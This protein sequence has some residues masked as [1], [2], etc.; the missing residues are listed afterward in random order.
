MYALCT[1]VTWIVIPSSV[2]LIGHYAF[3]NCTGLTSIALPNELTT[4]GI[5]TTV[6]TVTIIYVIIIMITNPN[7]IIR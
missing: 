1:S 7:P 3:Y 5:I 2:T 4:I 6:I